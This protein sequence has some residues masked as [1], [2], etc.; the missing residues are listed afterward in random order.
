MSSVRFCSRP[1]VSMMSTSAPSRR[2]SLIASNARPAASAPCWREMT[3]APMREPQIC[4]C[5][6]AAA[7][8]VSPAASITLLP[9][10]ESFAASLPMVVVLPEPFTP[11]TRMT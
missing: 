9:S 5:S 2:A 3:F 8:N 10:A 4:N 11:T 1:A 6:M 7:R